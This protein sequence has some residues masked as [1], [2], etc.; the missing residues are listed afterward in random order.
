MI[1]EVLARD[2]GVL[3]RDR[4]KMHEGMMQLI[5]LL[6]GKVLLRAQHLPLCQCPSVA[7][8]EPLN[9][10]RKNTRAGNRAPYNCGQQSNRK[11]PRPAQA[12]P[13][14]RTP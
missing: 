13:V 10:W 4:W 3:S 6:P 14:P 11:V 8:N 2:I 5:V 12:K 9:T 1:A 7:P